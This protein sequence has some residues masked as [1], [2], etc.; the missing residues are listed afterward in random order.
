MKV[1]RTT[2]KTYEVSSGCN[3]KKWGMPF[4]RFI[5]IRVRNNQSVK[6]FESCFI[7]GHRFSDDEIPNVVVVSSKG[8]R[9]SCDTC[10]EKVMRGG[11]RDE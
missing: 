1:T 9:F 8:N 2:T 10:Y 4:G 3:S 5:D 11:G 7:C 6:Q